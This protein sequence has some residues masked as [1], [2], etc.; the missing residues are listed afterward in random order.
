MNFTVNFSQY[1]HEVYELQYKCYKCS[2]HRET[3]FTRQPFLKHP[4]CLMLQ[5][6]VAELPRMGEQKHLQPSPD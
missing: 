2:S 4:E 6:H 5:V 3:L 1:I